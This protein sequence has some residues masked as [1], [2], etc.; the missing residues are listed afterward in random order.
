ML[1]NNLSD[2]SLKIPNLYCIIP[3][4]RIVYILQELYYD[5]IFNHRMTIFYKWAESESIQSLN[6]YQSNEH[7]DEYKIFN[8]SKFACRECL[9]NS[10]DIFQEVD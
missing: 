3:F 2:C 4:I 10:S 5:E 8:K 6:D 1:Y 7:I 9:I